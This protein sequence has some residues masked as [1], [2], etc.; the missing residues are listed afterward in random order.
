MPKL[1]IWK[2]ALIT[3][4]AGFAAAA[5]SIGHTE[6]ASIVAPKTA[7]PQ[8]APQMCPAANRPMTRPVSTYSSRYLRQTP[9]SYTARRNG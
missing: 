3:C 2:L 1:T 9:V 5:V 6:E 8:T 7:A 4:I